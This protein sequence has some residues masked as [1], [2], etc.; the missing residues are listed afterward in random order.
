MGD[1]VG[2]SLKAKAGWI[3]VLEDVRSHC[4]AASEAEQGVVLALHRCSWSSG[5]GLR[6]RRRPAGR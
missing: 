1:R 3:S 4:R 6:G 2:G 5:G